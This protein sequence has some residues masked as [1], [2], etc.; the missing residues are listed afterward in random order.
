[1]LPDRS[2]LA[3][4]EEISRASHHPRV[5]LTSSRGRSDFGTGFEWPSGCEFIP[6]HRLSGALL[7]DAP[8]TLSLV[9]IC[10]TGAWEAVV[11]AQT[12]TWFNAAGTFAALTAAA[13]VGRWPERRRMARLMV[14][15]I[16]TGALIDVHD[17]WPGSAVA[18]TIWLLGRSLNAPAYAQM[19][20]AYPFGRIFDRVERGFVALA[21]VVS[22]AWGL[23]PA[24]FGVRSLI[25]VG[26][27]FDL[28]PSS[29]TRSP[30]RSS[31]SA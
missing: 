1:M 30:Q 25:F 18:V 27:P 20:L 4:A 10:A 21:C 22:L 9:A 13:L 19:A 6:K 5:I 16:L 24:L 28:G 12:G 17:V 23:I 11:V 31:R 3:V 7:N 14:F 8:D 26:H 15:W 29:R 2:D